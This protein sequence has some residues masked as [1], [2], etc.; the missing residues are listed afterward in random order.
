MSEMDEIQKRAKEFLE[1]RRYERFKA[2][3]QVRFRVISPAEKLSLIKGG[4]FSNPASLSAHASETED[5]KHVFTEDI[6]LGG[7]RIATPQA[8]PTGIELWVNLGFPEVPIPVSA[9]ASVMWSRPV[10]GGGSYHSGL[11]FTEINQQELLKVEGF[12]RLQNKKSS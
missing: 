2:S 7:M 10:P 5:L 1:K 6:S 4:G 8:M 9:L 3:L 12:L 11:K